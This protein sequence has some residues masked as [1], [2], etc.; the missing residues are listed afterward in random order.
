MLD[1]KT[2]LFLI[3][4]MT[5]GIECAFQNE[6]A[7]DYF[8]HKL[9]SNI[10]ENEKI[11]SRLVGDSVGLL[12]EDSNGEPY[13]II[14]LEDNLVLF[15]LLIPEPDL[16]GEQS[17]DF[18]RIVLAVL[19]TFAMIETEQML[20]TTKNH[21]TSESIKFNISQIGIIV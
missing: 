14:K 5:E 4:A 20:D 16:S 10:E 18:G 19:S 11:K 3:K 15:A 8:V 7:K 1:D 6:D 21:A 13:G 9:Q 12:M 17:V 2:K